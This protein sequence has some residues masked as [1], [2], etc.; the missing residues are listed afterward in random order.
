M[1]QISETMN[2]DGI[3][4]STTSDC[5]TNTSGMCGTDSQTVA[6]GLT[7]MNDVAREP[8]HSSHIIHQHSGLNVNW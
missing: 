6:V 8:T 2:N 4:Q 5:T 7:R 1:K 3:G